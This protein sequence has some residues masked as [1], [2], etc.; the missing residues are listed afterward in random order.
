MKQSMKKESHEILKSRMNLPDFSS[1]IIQD[2]SPLTKEIIITQPT[3]NIS[4]I[5]DKGKGKT[6]FINSLSRQLPSKVKAEKEPE[7][8]REREKNFSQEIGYVNIKLY[9]CIKCPEPE[10]YKSFNSQIEEEIK[11]TSC[12]NKLELIRHISFID[13]PELTIKMN[14]ILNGNIFTDAA[15]LFVAADENLNIKEESINDN[16]NNNNE[17]EKEIFYENSLSKNIIIVQN[18]IDKVMKNN[19]AK[20]QYEQIKKYATYKNAQN[21]LIIPI[22]AQLNFNLDALIQYLISIQI[23]KRDLL[24]PPKYHILH[25]F[26]YSNIFDDSSTINKNG[27]LYGILIKGLL[28][29]GDNIEILPGIC[30][31]T[32]NKEIRTSPICGRITILQNE[33]NLANYVIPGGIINIGLKIE[34]SEYL[35][36]NK[37]EGNILGIQEKVGEVFYKIGVKCHFLRKL[38]KIEKNEWGHHLDYVTDI[39]KGEVLLLNINYI[40]VGG[41]IISIKGINSDEIYFELRKPICVEISE[42]IIISRKTGSIWRIIGWGEI[43]SE[44]EE[45]VTNI[46]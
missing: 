13:N 42:K 17:N 30:I 12:G 18:K 31:K 33:K 25:S 1:L 34:H 36:N 24:S 8:T 45:D 43:I 6:T 4:L 9:K 28:K 22:S 39:K 26:Y 32:K 10:C 16:D 35:K 41:D 44:A 11:C 14:M 19:M 37:L 5:G 21:S 46:T 3:M 20:Q 23:P 40:S 27:T 38:I 7:R 2:L 15:L 29:L